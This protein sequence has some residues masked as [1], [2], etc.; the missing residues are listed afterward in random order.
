MYALDIGQYRGLID[1][2]QVISSAEGSIYFPILNLN[3]GITYHPLQSENK[4]M[5]YV[6]VD[7]IGQI[8]LGTELISESFRNYLFR[9]VYNRS[10]SSSFQLKFPLD[11]K[12]IE[13]I[14]D[15][16]RGRTITFQLKINGIVHNKGPTVSLA[17]IRSQGSMP[18]EIPQ[19][20]WV[21]KILSIWNYGQA[22]LVEIY[23]PK[24]YNHDIL[25]ESY[26]H[27]ERAIRHFNNG[28]DRE[29]L[30]AIYDAFES[31]AQQI[32]CKD[33]DKNF[34]S[35]LLKGVSGQRHDKMKE[36][37]HRFC[38]YLHL[39]RHEQKK[40]DEPQKPPIPIDRKDSEFSITIAQV[41]YSYLSKLLYDEEK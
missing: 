31:M 38:Q 22:K 26:Q 14:E 4:T 35:K 7:L 41:I 6:I 11:Q 16:R 10:H 30:A 9:E 21:T 39:G 5:A 23:F 37:L 29:T 36:L 20:H 13:R 15:I 1:I 19:S 27:I 18:I 8:S 32:D 34:F 33:P 25:K 12:R 3:V 24:T 17:E 28:S 2:N 40:P